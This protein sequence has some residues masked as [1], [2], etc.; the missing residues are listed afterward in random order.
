M[1]T[2]APEA[3]KGALRSRMTCAGREPGGA[4]D[5]VGIFRHVCD[6]LTAVACRWADARER[7]GAL[8]QREVAANERDGDLGLL[9]GED[10]VE[11]LDPERAALP[12][13]AAGHPDGVARPVAVAEDE[14]GDHESAGQVD[15]VL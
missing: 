6:P 4:P 14:D 3:S 2:Q 11:G 5:P 8:V 12:V 15:L 9:A 10:H 7:P 1:V 13:G